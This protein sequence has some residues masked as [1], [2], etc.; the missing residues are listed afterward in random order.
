MP[1]S[2]A[3]H[4]VF[5]LGQPGAV[6]FF[7]PVLPALQEQ[8][9]TVTA[10][11]GFDA[12]SSNISVVVTSTSYK[13]AERAALE[14]AAE[15]G[16]P[17]VQLIDSWYDYR[18]RIEMTN[19]PGAMPDEIWVFDDVAKADAVSEGLPGDRIRAVGHPAWETV[20]ALPHAAATEVLLI[21][22]PV[23]SDMGARLGY[24][25][26]DFLDL[27]RRGLGKNYRATLAL[28]PRRSVADPSDG[29]RL[30]RDPRQAVKSSGAVI[31]MFSSFLIEAFLAGRRVVSV[32][33]NATREDFCILSRLGLIPRVTET[34]ALAPALASATP[35]P[36]GFDRRFAGSRARI[37]EAFAEY[38]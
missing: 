34:A 11:E 30:S 36:R 12:P 23:S 38:A 35:G 24:T 28:H 21:D 9:W 10:A 16:V 26:K 29:F 15:R 4:A 1:R 18:R 5:V 2:K 14:W 7:D 8:G 31:G 3:R 22:Q 6:E 13:P 33:P 27:V 19:G 17:T 32:Q 20:A 37:L 25:E